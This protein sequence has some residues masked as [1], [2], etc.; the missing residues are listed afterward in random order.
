MSFFKIIIM[1]FG[2]MPTDCAG[3]L[4]TN[5]VPVHGI[6]ETEKSEFS[7]LEGLSARLNIPFE[8]PSRKEATALLDSLREPAVV[9]VLTTITYFRHRYARK[10]I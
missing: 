7:P 6:W 10:I 1:G 2:K 3:I 5:N 9:L 4:L 8:R